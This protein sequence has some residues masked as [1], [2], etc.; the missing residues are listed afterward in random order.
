MDYKQILTDIA[1]AI[2]DTPEEVKVEETVEANQVPNEKEQMKEQTKE[3]P[4]EQPEKQPEKQAI[5]LQ[6]V[7]VFPA[8]SPTMKFL[9]KLSRSRYLR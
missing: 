3:Q 2:V 4:E 6:Y 8:N 5:A 7:S 1:R 9:R